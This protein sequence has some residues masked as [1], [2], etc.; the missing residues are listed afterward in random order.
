MGIYVR[1][2]Y[3][4]CRYMYTSFG[5]WGMSESINDAPGG[6]FWWEWYEIGWGYNGGAGWGNDIHIYKTYL[7]LGVCKMLNT[8]IKYTFMMLLMGGRVYDYFV[9]FLDLEREELYTIKQSIIKAAETG[10]AVCIC[11]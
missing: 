1:L 2:S 8:W 7:I 3:L 9:C 11:C 5:W 4:Y 6:I 10:D